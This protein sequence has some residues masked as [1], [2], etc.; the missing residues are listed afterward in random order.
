M[1]QQDDLNVPVIATVGIASVALTV[2]FVFV[3]QALYQSFVTAN[4]ERKVVNVPSVT[5]DS[6]L[7]EQ[8]AA[9]SRFSWK[10]RDGGIVTIPIDRAMQ[11]VTTEL[12]DSQTSGTKG[13][14][15]RRE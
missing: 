13:S 7:A 12:R 4:I 9:L 6:K 5:S 1:A 14:S 11:L 8:E 2:A 15:Q 10:D 3:V